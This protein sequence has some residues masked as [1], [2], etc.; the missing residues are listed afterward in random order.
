MAVLDARGDDGD[1]EVAQAEVEIQPGEFT[2][3][4]IRVALIQVRG[5]WSYSN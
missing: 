3:A 2:A 4:G 5:P 1:L